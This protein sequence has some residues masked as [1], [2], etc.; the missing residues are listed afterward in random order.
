MPK[1]PACA[2]TAGRRPTGAC[3]PPVAS[4][5]LLALFLPAVLS[6][7]GRQ[8]QAAAPMPPPS[9]VVVK[10]EVEPVR[11]Q[12][13][14]VGRVVAADKVELQARVQGF[15]KERRFTEGQQVK[16]GELLFLI[17]PDHYESVVQQREADVAKAE[18]DE[19][20]TRAQLAR[21]LELLKGKNISQA[22]VDELKAA[23]GI[24]KAT[25]AQAKAALDAAKLNLSY[26]RITAPIA[27]RIGLAKYTVGNLVG[28][29]T[30]ALA[31]I[32]SRDPIYVQFPVTQR[33]LLE[34]RRAIAQKGGD[35]A[36][37]VVR[38]R[39]PDGSW[40]DKP[41]HLNFVDVTTDPGTDTLTLRAEFPNPDGLLVDGQ[42]VGVVAEAGEPESAILVPQSA[43]Q[44][45]QQGTFVLIVDKENKA[46]VRRISTGQNV[47]AMV[48]V[49]KG[50][51]AGDLV[52]TQGT[53]KVRPGQV[54]S[55]APE[56]LPE[57]SG[58]P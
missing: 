23:E 26:T 34:A 54:V 37:V 27:G 53:Q 16:V 56:E 43:L 58:A 24:S 47:G 22:K 2:P 51:Q 32:V 45:D 52:I 18:A 50:L 8:E 30:G 38:A 41:G 44:L 14:F 46:Q 17:E 1:M 57:G 7:C 36:K 4:L 48:V 10:A 11:E 40:Y 6:G 35:P 20:N 31:T 28:P 55:A 3:R 25:I 13:Q 5:P 33:K 49:K 42:Y 19:E 12:T 9:V 29:S 39:L 21:G 15:L